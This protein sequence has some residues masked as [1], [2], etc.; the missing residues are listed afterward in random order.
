[1]FLYRFIHRL[2]LYRRIRKDRFKNGVCEYSP[3]RGTFSSLGGM[4]LNCIHLQY[5]PNYSKRIT[6][7]V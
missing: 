6:M 7:V 4:G 3:A 1:M 2:P 5:L